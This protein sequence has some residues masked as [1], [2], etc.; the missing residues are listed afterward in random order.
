MKLFEELMELRESKV[1]LDDVLGIPYIRLSRLQGK[2]L[3]TL[4][5]KG[6]SRSMRL[7][8]E[9]VMIGGPEKRP[10]QWYPSSLPQVKTW[11]EVDSKDD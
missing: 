10:G 7:I 3:R 2:L 9:W 1:A 5:V 8:L 6:V 11:I 4:F